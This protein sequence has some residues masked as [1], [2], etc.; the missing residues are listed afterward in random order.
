MPVIKTALDKNG[1][2]RS[3]ATFN[4][5]NCNDETSQRLDEFKRRG[6]LCKKCKLKENS[7]NEFNNKNLE[8]T[9]AKV[10]KSHLNKR[11]AKRGLICNLSSEEVFNLVKSNCHYCGDGF[12][13]TLYY[14]QPNFKYIFYYNGIDRIDSSKGYI[15]GNVVP[16]CKTCNVS[17]MD[18]NYNDFINHIKKIYKNLNLCQ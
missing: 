3:I 12:S 5:I 17:K 16:C 1:R 4:C 9:C 10:I 8:F 6:A 11:Y 18:M 13:N 14:N 15:K 2:L 7:K